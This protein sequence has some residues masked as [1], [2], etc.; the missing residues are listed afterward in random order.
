MAAVSAK[1]DIAIIVEVAEPAADVS[2]VA[3]GGSSGLVGIG[4]F[5]A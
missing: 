1:R 5:S 3:V 2:G 4:V